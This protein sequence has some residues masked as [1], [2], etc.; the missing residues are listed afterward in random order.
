MTQY[1]RKTI[2][3]M[4]SNG[5]QLTRPFIE[6]VREV[7]DKIIAQYGFTKPIKNKEIDISWYDDFPVSDGVAISIDYHTKEGEKLV[8]LLSHFLKKEHSFEVRS[9]IPF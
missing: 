3:I 1:Q 7:T 4:P 9:I 5:Y 6:D 2:N 8:N